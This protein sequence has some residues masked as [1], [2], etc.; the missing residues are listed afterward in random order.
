MAAV[1]VEHGLLVDK[2]VTGIILD[3]FGHGTDGAVWGGEVLQGGYHAFER[4]A[5]LRYVPQPGGDRAALEPVRMAVSLL[6]SAKMADSLHGVA[7]NEDIERIAS[8]RD[9]SPLTSSAGRL[10]DGAAALLGIAPKIQD[11]EG[12]AAMRLEAAADSTVKDAY[13]LPLVDDVLDT[14][15]LIRALMADP[16]NRATRAARFINGLADG[17]ILAAVT[18]DRDTVVLGGGCM[19]NR[20][21][22]HRL[23]TGLEKYDVKV[24]VPQKLPAGDGGISTGQ[25]AC[26]AVAIDK[27]EE[28][29][30]CV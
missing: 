21:L 3:G 20:L 23:V 28:D 25:A 17:L 15:A 14:R 5:H 19:I 29:A 6:V 12:E 27:D 13:P 18:T 22:L 10:F 7:W 26:A 16:S 1:M 9:V 24:L 11:F 2:E 8:Y 30:Q 4:V